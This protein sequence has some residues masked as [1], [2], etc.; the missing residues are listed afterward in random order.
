MITNI[1]KDGRF[2]A[3]ALG[4]MGRVV[5]ADGAT[6]AEAMNECYHQLKEQRAEAYWHEQSMSHLSLVSYGDLCE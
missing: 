6:R 1:G 4:D 3:S 5:V 2:C